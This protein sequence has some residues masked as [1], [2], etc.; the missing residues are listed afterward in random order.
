MNNPRILLENPHDALP[1]GNVRTPKTNE[2][3]VAIVEDIT[4]EIRQATLAPPDEIKKKIAK[5]ADNIHSKLTPLGSHINRFGCTSPELDI[6]FKKLNQICV[7]SG[8]WPKV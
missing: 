4:A 3:R 8:I 2:E 7:D 5:I 6:A 1:C